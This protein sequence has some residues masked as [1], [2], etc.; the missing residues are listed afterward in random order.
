MSI[1]DV[2]SFKRVCIENGFEYFSD[3]SNT[4]TIVYESID[5]R[6]G[7]IYYI[8]PDSSFAFIFRE[9]IG[10]SDIEIPYNTEFDKIYKK[11]KQLCQFSRISEDNGVSK[12]CYKC[13]DSK[14]NGEVGF[15][16]LEGMGVIHFTKLLPN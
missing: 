8:Y 13:N 10:D 4:N 14:F 15:V 11:V 1:N 9:T 16:V 2:N 7:G 3:G 5:G 12:A 6:N